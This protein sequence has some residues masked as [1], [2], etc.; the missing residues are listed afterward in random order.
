MIRLTTLRGDKLCILHSQIVSV[1]SHGKKSIIKF[2]LNHDKIY[3]QESLIEVMKQM[4]LA[5][6]AKNAK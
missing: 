3:V 2:G 1:E 4:D 6:T 5:K